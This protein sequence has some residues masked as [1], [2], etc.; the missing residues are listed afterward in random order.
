[1]ENHDPA[2]YQLSI[3]LWFTNVEID[4][5][6]WELVDPNISDVI[7]G[8]QDRKQIKVYEIALSDFEPPEQRRK[9]VHYTQK[10][11]RKRNGQCPEDCD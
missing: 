10:S 2:N 1:L 5:A 4:D 7:S 9:L 3:P 6:N 8:T 11:L